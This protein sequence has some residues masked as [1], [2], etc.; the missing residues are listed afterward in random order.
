MSNLKVPY[1]S[2]LDSTTAAEHNNDCGAACGVMLLRACFP[3]NKMTVDEFYDACQPTGDEYLSVSQIA[4]VLSKHGVA[5]TWKTRNT[6]T[7]LFDY[8]SDG[9]P[10]M[11]LVNYGELVDTGYTQKKTFRGAHFV[12]V[13]G[14]DHESVFIHDPYRTEGGS[15]LVIDHDSWDYAWNGCTMQNNPN[16]GLLIAPTLHYPLSAPGEVLYTVEITADVL[17]VREDAGVNFDSVGY[18]KR[19]EKADVYYAAD[20]WLMIGDDRWISGKYTKRV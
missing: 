18:M 9:C 1:I 8:L 13:V 20:G 5:T 15:D 2:Q 3:D 19:G 6:L 11:A 4:A 10:C 14:I 12:V 16:G 17:T 7:N